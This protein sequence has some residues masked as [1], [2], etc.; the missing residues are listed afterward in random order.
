MYKRQDEYWLQR[1]LAVAQSIGISKQELFEQYCYDEFIA[2]MD[3][4]NEMHSIDSDNARDEEVY[5]DEL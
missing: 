1:W 2:M 3:A 4:Y 5:A